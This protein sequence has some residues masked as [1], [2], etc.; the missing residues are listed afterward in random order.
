MESCSSHI[1]SLNCLICSNGIITFPQEELLGAQIGWRQTEG[2]QGSLLGGGEVEMIRESEPGTRDSV[3]GEYQ[4]LCVRE[5]GLQSG[6][7]QSGGAQWSSVYTHPLQGQNP[8]S[9]IPP[10]NRKS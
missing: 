5:G 10:I 6:K 7:R 2:N 9:L 4:L 3:L 8:G 1:W